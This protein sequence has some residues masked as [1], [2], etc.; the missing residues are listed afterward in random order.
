MPAAVFPTM[1]FFRTPVAGKESL[2]TTHKSNTGGV[3]KVNMPIL[4]NFF[5]LSG[6]TALRRVRQS[7]DNM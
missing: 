1:V 3:S 7:E 6:E 5:Y 2:C 4:A